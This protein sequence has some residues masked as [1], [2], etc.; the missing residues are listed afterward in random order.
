[1]STCW[2]LRVMRSA[3]L[4]LLMFMCIDVGVDLWQGETGDSDSREVGLASACPMPGVTTI[5][6][7][8]AQPPLNQSM[9]ECFC[10]CSHLETQPQTVVFVF[11][12]SSPRE[13]ERATTHFL[14]PD[15]SPI[16]H[17]PQQIL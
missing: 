10:C 13:P 11:L 5:S 12:E 3:A 16:Y 17:P 7:S 14:T 6:A 8:P 15:P 2:N 1:M 9:H 4:A